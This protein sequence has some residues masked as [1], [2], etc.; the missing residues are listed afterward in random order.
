[1]GFIS[2]KLLDENRKF[3]AEFSLC[4]RKRPLIWEFSKW[5][6]NSTPKN[7]GKDKHEV[8]KFKW[9]HV[10]G[11]VDMKSE[12]FSIYIDG[13]NMGNSSILN[14]GEGRESGPVIN[15]KDKQQFELHI[16][17][18]R[19]VPG[20][21]ANRIIGMV[22][23]FNMYTYIDEEMLKNISAC[24]FQKQGDFISW[25]NAEWINTGTDDSLIVTKDVEFKEICPERKPNES[26]VFVIPHPIY[27]YYE[28]LDRCKSLTMKMTVPFNNEEHEQIIS[29]GNSV[30]M[31]KHCFNGGR[32]RVLFAMQMSSKGRFFD[33]QTDRTT[34]E[35]AKSYAGWDINKDYE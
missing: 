7:K 35:Y 3:T 31:R 5:K 18:H 15:L 26:Q 29:G 6:S 9:V 17:T 13:E 11:F 30:A 10:C 33:P 22:Q 19:T 32:Q 2:I 12:M 28:A 21:M 27:N 1:M 8:K 23:G 25:N 34:D 16:G 4:Q 24:K 20:D 14:D